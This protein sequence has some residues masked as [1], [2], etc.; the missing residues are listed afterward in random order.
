[1]PAL[2]RR[3]PAW[4]CRLQPGLAAATTRRAGGLNVGHF[5][6]AEPAGHCRLREIVAAGTATAGVG[7]WQLDKDQTGDLPQQL[8]GGLANALPVRQVAGV[9]VGD[10]LVQLSWRGHHGQRNKELRY[11]A[12]LGAK[13]PCPL[14]IQ[15]I[16][17][18]ERAVFLQHGAAAG[19]IGDDGTQLGRK[20]IDVPARAR[21]RCSAVRRYASATRRN[22][23]GG[24]EP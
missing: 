2:A 9:V 15:R 1:M 24:Q 13:R 7:V 14:R 23:L 16:V 3:S 17:G 11:V 8:P 5:P 10:A 6:V 20:R 21:E 12:H 19:G 18:Q 4:I 22:S